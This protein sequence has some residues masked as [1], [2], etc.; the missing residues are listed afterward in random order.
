MYLV[1]TVFFHSHSC[2]VSICGGMQLSPLIA[3]QIYRTASNKVVNFFSKYGHNFI[4]VQVAEMSWERPKVLM[5]PRWLLGVDPRRAWVCLQESNSQPTSL[6]GLL[7]GSGR[8]GRVLRPWCLGLCS[9]PSAFLC[10]PLA[11]LGKWAGV[12][13]MWKPPPY[14]PQDSERQ[15]LV[16]CQHAPLSRAP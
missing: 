16:K 10:L 15:H 12:V 2:R 13:L 6:S 14:R 1:T 7:R 11:I 8:S 5:P 3:G 9:P 4:V